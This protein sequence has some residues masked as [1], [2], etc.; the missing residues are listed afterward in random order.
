MKQCRYICIRM[1]CITLYRVPCRVSS[2][3]VPRGYCVWCA[4]IPP[5]GNTAG[6]WLVMDAADSSREVY[7]GS[8]FTGRLYNFT[9]LEGRVV[10]RE[11]G[12]RPLGSK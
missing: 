8:L 4:V 3:G 7:A 6:Y 5:V 9:I 12:A 11:Y 1:Q 10:G 2:S